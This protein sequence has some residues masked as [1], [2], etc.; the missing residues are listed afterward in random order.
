[1]SSIISVV[2]SLPSI[3][4]KFV[5][6]IDKY[7]AKREIKEQLVSSLRN[8]LEQFSKIFDQMSCFSEQAKPLFKAVKENPNH[9]SINN[10]FNVAVDAPIIFTQ[11]IESFIE[12]AR[13]CSEVSVNSAFMSHLWDYNP[14]IHDYVQRMGDTYVKRN[15][16]VMVG[17][18][19]FRFFQTYEQKIFGKVKH[20]DVEKTVEEYEELFQ[21]IRP[22]MVKP[23]IIERELRRKLLRNFKKM[24]S[25]VKKMKIQKSVIDLKLYCPTK[26]LPIVILIE[27]NYP[28]ALLGE[29][30]TTK[31]KLGDKSS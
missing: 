8:E 29:T 23:S 12:L 7:Q 17:G 6:S 20:N 16:S 31:K 18:E 13:G 1:M 15:S 30:E 24:T 19:Y 4:L 14:M 27:E 26:I 21:K 3:L 28:K 25:T 22:Y 10:L 5:D 9:A 2:T 11:L